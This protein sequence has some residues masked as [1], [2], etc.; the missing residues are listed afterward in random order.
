MG[1]LILMNQMGHRLIEKETL[2]KGELA[3][4]KLKMSA[5]EAQ[6]KAIEQMIEDERALLKEKMNE[7]RISTLV[8]EGKDGFYTIETYQGPP[9]V[10]IKDGVQLSELHEL[11]PDFIRTKVEP[12]LLEIKKAL[13]PRPM[14]PGEQT[15]TTVAQEKLMS[16]IQLQRSNIIKV[17]KQGEGQDGTHQ[18]SVS[19]YNE[20]E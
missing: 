17:T 7:S 11:N 1:D 6:K 12:N 5:L 10:T 4:I 9:K 8:V 15:A 20:E 19:Q 14:R 3:D 13:K 2:L 16:L 18:D